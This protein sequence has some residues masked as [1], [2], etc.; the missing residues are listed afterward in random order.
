MSTRGVPGRVGASGVR[1]SPP[2]RQRRR[3][4]HDSIRPLH[5]GDKHCFWWC[6]SAKEWLFLLCA[7]RDSAALASQ[8]ETRTREGI[9]CA[10][11]TELAKSKKASTST[12]RFI[13]SDLILC[14]TLQMILFRS[15]CVDLNWW[16]SRILASKHILGI[17]SICWRNH[18]FTTE[19]TLLSTHRTTH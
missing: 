12:L 16:S 6:Q 13:V 4:E 2:P 3:H 19:L 15:Q 14:G 17:P 18:C 1:G 11:M 5:L 8:Q 10:R 9:W 7:Y